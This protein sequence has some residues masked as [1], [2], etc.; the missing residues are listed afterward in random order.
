MDDP[1][2]AIHI[3]LLLL[4]NARIIPKDAIILFGAKFALQWLNEGAKTR[5]QA[6]RAT[7]QPMYHSRCP[8]FARGET[9]ASGLANGQGQPDEWKPTQSNTCIPIKNKAKANIVG[10]TQEERRHDTIYSFFSN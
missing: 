1:D 10:R 7:K 5:N 9:C 4:S 3:I 2:W 6:T 8:A